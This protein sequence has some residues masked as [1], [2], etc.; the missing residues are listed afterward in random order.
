[1]A[2]HVPDRPA[3]EIPPTSPHAGMINRAGL[4]AVM[5]FGHCARKG[6]IGA[7]PIQRSNSAM[8]ARN[9]TR[10]E[11]QPLRPPP[12]ATVSPAMDCAH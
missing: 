9:P 1:M 3:T 5:S 7:G 4:A 8:P 11:H 2:G 12:P 6:R 10:T